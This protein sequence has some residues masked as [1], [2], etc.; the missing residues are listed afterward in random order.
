MTDQLNEQVSAFVDNELPDGECELFVRRLC[1]DE[2]MQFAVT[3]FALIGDAMRGELLAADVHVSRHISAAI[4]AGAG[5]QETGTP[6]AART[7]AWSRWLRPVSGLA[8]AATVAAVAVLS[9]QGFDSP[10]NSELPSSTVAELSSDDNSALGPISVMRPKLPEVRPAS[11]MPQSRMDQY[12]L[13]H[14]GYANSFG[15]QSVMGARNIGTYTLLPV[16]ES[17]QPAAEPEP[18]EDTP[19]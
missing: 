18:I 14:R 1:K 4:A 12:L 9:L 17:A 6:G 2:Q 11:V 19:E 3:R 16:P 10:D 5:E 15:R 13:R 8:V 7:P